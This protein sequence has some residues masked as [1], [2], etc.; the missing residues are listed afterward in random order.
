MTKT[1]LLLR[2]GKSNWDAQYQL[3]HDR[4]LAKRGRK[5]ASLM[6]RYLTALG[7]A[8]DHACSSSAT[9]AQDTTQRAAEAGGWTCP[10]A[11]SERLYHASP[12]QVLEVVRKTDGGVA[13]LL[14]AGHEPTWSLLAGRLIGA[15]SLR[16]PTA[17]IARIDLPIENWR[18]ADYGGG[19]LVWLVTPKILERIGWGDEVS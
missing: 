8:P 12:D 18:E 17:A 13:R 3:D 5:A 6:G 11:I 2:H 10:I 19:T 7:E 16:F 1:L 4:P 15:A 14:L 9:R